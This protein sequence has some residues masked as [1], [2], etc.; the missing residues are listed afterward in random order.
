MIG[1]ISG[2]SSMQG[3]LVVAMTPYA[4]ISDV[5]ASKRHRVTREKKKKK[6]LISASKHGNGIKQQQTSA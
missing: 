2:D 1:I 3:V 5:A 4:M 6:K